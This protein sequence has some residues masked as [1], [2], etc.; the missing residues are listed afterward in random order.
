METMYSAAPLNIIFVP[1]QGI[2]LVYDITVE[3]SFKHIT[4][5]L[6]NIEDV[7]AEFGVGQ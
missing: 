1:F 7:S 3:D 6:Q 4:Q 5:W 2:V